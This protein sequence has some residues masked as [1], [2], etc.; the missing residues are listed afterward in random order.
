MIYRTERQIIKDKHIIKVLD[1]K[2]RYSK[3]LYNYVNFLIRQEF[4]HTGKL[5]NKNKLLHELTEQN[6]KD[7]RSLPSNVSQQ[8]IFQLFQSWSNFFKANKQ[9]NKTP[10]KFRSRP[11]P[12]KY[13]DKTKGK[14]LLIF[15]KVTARIKNGKLITVKNVL[16]ELITKVKPENYIGCRVIPNA[17]CY[18]LEIVYQTEPSNKELNKT[19]IL[20]IDL[21]INNLATCVNNVGL[22]PFIINGKPLKS[23]NCYS[24]KKLSQIQ[25]QVPNKSCRR[26]RKTYLKRQN[27]IRD[28]LHKSSRKI[29]DYCIENN[30]G[31]VIIGYNAG[32]K[33]D[34]KLRNSVKQQFIYIPFDMFVNQLTYK[35]ENYEIQI[36]QTN[37]SYTSKIDHMVL[38]EMKH[39]EH[40]MGKRVKRGLFQSSTN[41]LINADVNGAIGIMRKVVGDSDFKQILNIGFVNNPARYNI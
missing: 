14:N 30:I 31:T 15:N 36:I 27:K 23:I 2:C 32:W 35:C 19:R 39:H 22:K 37:E 25:E 20:S 33:N 38:E 11:K 8:I 16:P 6:N 1:E 21:G 34:V 3:N 24:N 18:I 5:P 17:T 9:Y 10:N 12:P 4:F 28:Y 7:F 29:I 41:T 26:L 40:Y 13:K